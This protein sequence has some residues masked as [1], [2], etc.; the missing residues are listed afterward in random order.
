MN[1][2]E[3]L[4][5]DNAEIVFEDR[6]IHVRM[7]LRAADTYAFA[8]TVDCSHLDWQVS[9]V[10]QISNALSQVFSAVEHLTLG[11]EVHSRS[12]EE[13]NDVDRIEWRNILRSFSNVK[14]LRVEDRL[15][16]E[17]TRCLR[18]EGGEL[19]LELLPEL[20]EFTCPGS[21]ATGD[22]FTSF[23]DAR[24]NA[25]RPV[26]LGRRPVSSP[27]LYVCPVCQRS[28]NRVQARD[29]HLQLYLPRPILCPI[30]GCTWTG[31][32]QWD[33]REHWTRKHPDAGQ[34]VLV[35][36]A[37]E[38]YDPR[39]FVKLIV[40]GTRVD[41]VARSA[42]AKAQECLG[43]LGKQYVGAE[44]LG[45]KRNLRRWVSIPLSQLT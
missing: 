32:R 12:S 33:F 14:T 43:R 18:L 41:E 30:Q 10:A 22:A 39:E 38:L 6:Q 17:L 42:F 13:H 31:R 26:A 9:S 8:V 23:V 36:G 40:D 35:E 3:N 37:N 27:S 5:F 2:T 1:A 21:R 24:Q 16:E 28:F 11:H 29:R 45:R 19:P 25:G 44:V 20:Q 4:G 34:V 15:V 7:F